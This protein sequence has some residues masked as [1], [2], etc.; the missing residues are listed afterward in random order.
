MNKIA[1]D[2]T[3][4]VNNFLETTPKPTDW[5]H[6]PAPGKWS[7]KEILGHLIDSAHINLQRFVRCTYEENFKLIYFQDEWVATQHYQEAD[8]ADTI[9]LWKLVNAQIVRVLDNYPA[10]RWQATCDSNRGE[11]VYRTVEFLANDY[12]RHMQHHLDQISALSN[13]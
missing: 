11:P 6:Y 2:L 10:D 5:A 4:T 13:G 12:I 7:G 1:A 9:N 8:I 3:N